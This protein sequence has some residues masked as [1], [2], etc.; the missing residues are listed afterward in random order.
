MS[1]MVTCSPTTYVISSYSN[2]RV[3]QPTMGLSV[4]S[5]TPVDIMMNP[6]LA[7]EPPA[8]VDMMESIFMK[9]DPPKNIK[10]VSIDEK[11]IMET[12]N[13]QKTADDD[14][15]IFDESD[16][17]AIGMQQPVGFTVATE[18]PETTTEV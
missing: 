18:A 4:E 6:V 8:A 1:R 2:V 7:D 12:I 17:V 9:T 15:N 14:G 13:N 5:Q 11:E 3:Q 10:T 16:L